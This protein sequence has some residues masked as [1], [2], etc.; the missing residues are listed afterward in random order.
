MTNHE[1]QLKL[2]AFMDG[3]LSVREAAE[4]REWLAQDAEAHALLSE[5]RNTTAALKGNEPQCRLP[6]TRE[7]FWSKIEREIER[8]GAQPMRPRPVAAGSLL[9]WL[10]RH[11]MPAV[12][13]AAVCSALVFIA[14]RSHGP[15]LRIGEMALV[16][17][18]MGSYTYRDQADKMTMVW[19]Y[20]RS[21][22]DSQV[23]D[24]SDIDNVTT[25]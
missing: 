13:V 14:V 10:R 20:D 6:E 19:L 24:S 25:E 2:Q 15:Q 7:F 22:A 18:D 23:A 16:S 8:Q 11:L 3:E 12:G 9:A 4:V 5:L 1:S 21:S 17:D